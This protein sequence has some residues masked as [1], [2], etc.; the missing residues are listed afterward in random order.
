MWVSALSEILKLGS[1]L[2]NCKISSYWINS[3]YQQAFIF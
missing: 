2:E 1:W 3:F